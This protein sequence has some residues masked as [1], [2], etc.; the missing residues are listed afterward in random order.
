MARL[1]YF[2]AV[3]LFGCLVWCH[4][5]LCGDSLTFTFT[6]TS[7][8]SRTVLDKILSSRPVSPKNPRLRLRNSFSITLASN[9]SADTHKRLLRAPAN[10]S[11]LTEC[12]WAQMRESGTFQTSLA[13]SNCAFFSRLG[14]TKIA[15]FIGVTSLRSYL[16]LA[17]TPRP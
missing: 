7:T 12:C 16:K 1:G 14:L 10:Q 9:D 2:R 5:L 11:W 15:L 3:G 8:A 4:D 6:S 17:S 13:Q